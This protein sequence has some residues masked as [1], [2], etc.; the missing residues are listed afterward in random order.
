[1]IFFGYEQGESK[2]LKLREVSV[3]AS[4]AELLLLASFLT[5]AAQSM[6]SN[7]SSFGHEHYQD[8]CRSKNVEQT[9]NIDFIVVGETN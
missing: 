8:W 6:K 9:P 7:A 4:P 1:M 2:L 5:E 3:Q